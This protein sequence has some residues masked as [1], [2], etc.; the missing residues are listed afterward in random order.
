MPNVPGAAETLKFLRERKKSHPPTKIPFQETLGSSFKNVQDRNR[1]C[2]D[3]CSA[4]ISH[5]HKLNANT[6]KV[7]QVK[8]FLRLMR[9]R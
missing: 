6:G 2:G 7:F 9:W 1:N 4:S 3:L 8:S 5:Y